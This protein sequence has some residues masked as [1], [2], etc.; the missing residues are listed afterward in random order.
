MLTFLFAVIRHPTR[1]RIREKGLHRLR[2]ESS[3]IV[4]GKAGRDGRRRALGWSCR[5]VRL[6]LEAEREKLGAQLISVSPLSFSPGPK[7]TGWC[8]PHSGCVFSPRLTLPGNVL[9]GTP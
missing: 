7:L 2:S 1:T 3:A 6:D 4:A 9:A 8:H 5:S